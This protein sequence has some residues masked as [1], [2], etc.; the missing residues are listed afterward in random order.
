[1]SITRWDPWGEM[2]SL[3]E[4]MDR[5]LEE[6]VVRPQ[7]TTGGQRGQGG[8]T[9]GAAGLLPL[10]VE[11]KGDNYVITA[12]VPGVNPQ[13]VEISV[14]GDTL[15]IHAQRHEEHQEGGEGKRFLMR[16]QRFGSFERTVTLP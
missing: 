8:Q 5:L 4:A 16:E 1:M 11:E 15:R 9:R 3:R 10:D 7:A 2:V 6:S 14:L 13:N 12:P